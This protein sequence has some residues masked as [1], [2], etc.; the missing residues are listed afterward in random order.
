MTEN[1]R[2]IV[3][4]LITQI[5]EGK[6]YA[7]E[8]LSRIVS[9]R[10]LALAQSI[11]RN[12]ALAEDVVQDSFVRIVNNAHKYKP[13]TNGYGWIC[14]ITQNVALSALKRDR[15]QLCVN[16]DECL[17]LSDGND[18]AEN[19]DDKLTV[20]Q[21]LRCLTQEERL[22]IFYKYFADCTVRDIA[23]LTGKSKSAVHRA[24][25]GAERKMRKFIGGGTN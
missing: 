25:I 18:V 13:N 5:A 19:A 9:G 8:D 12:R 11:V 17:W 23:A 16:I 6:Q 3:N 20:R 4:V 1:M 7:L 2:H 22:V 14:K 10:M 15:Q 24:E 21:A